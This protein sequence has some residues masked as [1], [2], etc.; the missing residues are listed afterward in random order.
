MSA[1]PPSPSSIPMSWAS[2]RMMA[3]RSPTGGAS[4]SRRS[5]TTTSSVRV[6]QWALDVAAGVNDRVGDRLGDRELDA[7]HVH[8]ELGGEVA[9]HRARD[10]QAGR[11]GREVL[12][13][14]ADSDGPH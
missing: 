10:R 5:R 9:H 6:D 8:A 1:C 4:P 11:G 2:L 12:L 14:R 7:A 13:Q 3:I